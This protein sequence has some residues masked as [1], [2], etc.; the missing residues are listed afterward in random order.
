MLNNNNIITYGNLPAQIAVSFV[1]EHLKTGYREIK[2]KLGLTK[3]KV[4]DAYENSTDEAELLKFETL[5]EAIKCQTLAS[6]FPKA[7]SFF[8]DGMPNLAEGISARFYTPEQ[9]AK[10]ANDYQ[11]KVDQLLSDLQEVTAPDNGFKMRIIGI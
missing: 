3:Y 10:M 4:L 2:L 7:N 1:D 11:R 8:L 6:L 9:A 5:Q